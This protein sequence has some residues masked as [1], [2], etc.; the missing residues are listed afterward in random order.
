M[1]KELANANIKQ[2][3]KPV[4]ISIGMKITPKVAE[5]NLK[6]NMSNN[7]DNKDYISRII[8]RT[9][10]TNGKEII[11]KKIKN[12]FF[13]I[14]LLIITDIIDERDYFSLQ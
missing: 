12:A 1:S 11:A 7:I 9:E 8:Y 6:Q 14:I 13:I 2:T 5:I 10:K 4:I 3:N